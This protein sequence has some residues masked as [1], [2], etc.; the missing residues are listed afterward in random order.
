M[1]ISFS[2]RRVRSAA[3]GEDHGGGAEEEAAAGFRG[4]R[5]SGV[6]QPGGVLGGDRRHEQDGAER[7]HPTGKAIS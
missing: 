5:G 3:R 1:L 7:A 6:V 2:N 4:Q